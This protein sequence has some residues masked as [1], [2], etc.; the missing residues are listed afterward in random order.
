PRISPPSR[1]ASQRP[2]SNVYCA[3]GS[4]P[5]PYQTH[6]RTPYRRARP[7]A[8]HLRVTCGLPPRGPESPRD[9]TLQDSEGR[10]S[11]R[12]PAHRGLPAVPAEAQGPGPL[13]FMGP[14]VP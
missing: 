8:G 2:L 5:D 13:S 14:F 3:S 10:G 1:G 11:A 4:E 9:Q 6:V 7:G 12:G